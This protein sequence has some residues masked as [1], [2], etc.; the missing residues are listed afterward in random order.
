VGVVWQLGTAHQIYGDFESSYGEK[1]VVPYS[2][3]LGYRF[4]F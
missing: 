4:R 3:N 2:V 1:Y